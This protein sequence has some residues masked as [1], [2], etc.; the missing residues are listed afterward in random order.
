MAR[1]LPGPKPSAALRANGGLR[2]TRVS[3]RSRGAGRAG[4]YA[5]VAAL[6]AV[7]IGLGCD[8]SADMG[9]AGPVVLGSNGRQRFVITLSEPAPALDD[10]RRLLKDNPAGAAAYVDDRR[11]ALA[12]PALDSALVAFNGR[13]VERW[14][15]SSQLTVEMDREGLATIR[16]VTG[17]KSVEPDV[18]LR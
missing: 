11:A 18:P 9:P 2:P 12:R 15:M 5:A 16:A 14:W 10:Y 7:L 17:V 3:R 6:L 1:S 8:D 13:V 4:V